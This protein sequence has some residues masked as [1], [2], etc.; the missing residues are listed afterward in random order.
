MTPDRHTSRETFVDTGD[1]HKLYVHDWGNEKA[2][3][4]I[5][6]LHGGPG[7]GCSDRHKRLFD[8]MRQRVIFFDQRGAGRSAP[9]G[10]L[11]RNTTQ[12][13]V[14][15]IEKVT[16]ACK[17]DSFIVVGGSWGSCLALV[18]TLEHPKHVQA[19]VL[20]GIFTGSQAEID[21]LSRGTWRTFFPEAWNELLA[22]TPKT[23]YRNPLAYHTARILGT[24]DQTAKAS[25][26]TVSNVEGAL[27]SLDDRFTPQ[28]FD[29]FDPTSTRIETHYMLNHCFLP[30]RYILSNAHKVTIPVW[31]VQGRYDFVCPPSTAYE[32]DRKLPNSQL[33]PTVAGHY[34]SERASWDVTRTILLQLTRT[35]ND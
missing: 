20:R 8:P 16:N 26:Y 24:D 1:G 2:K 34:G 25:A 12:D 15:D 35:D 11:E 30:D 13:L 31:L 17:L 22:A 6:F 14:A 5:L 18:Y 21:W 4:P 19:L 28:L 29:E 7:S 23:H 3:T 10:T 27:L 9:Y 32:L 33:I